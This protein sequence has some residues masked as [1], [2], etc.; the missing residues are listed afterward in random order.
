[1]HRQTKKTSISFCPKLH[2]NKLL[3]HL[4]HDECERVCPHLELVRVETGK[5]LCSP[6][7][8]SEYAYFPLDCFVSLSHIME[9]DSSYAAALVGHEGVLCHSPL[10]DMVMPYT[11]VCQIAGHVV[12]I[13]AD[14]LQ[15]EFGSSHWF[16]RRLLRY[17]QALMAHMGLTAACTRHHAL[18]EQLAHLLLQIGDRLSCDEIALTQESISSLL[19]VRRERINKAALELQ[20]EGIIRYSRGRIH[21]L[22]RPRLLEQSCGCYA[23]IR[24]QFNRLLEEGE[25]PSPCLVSAVK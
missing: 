13:R 1:M 7:E 18:I 22:D 14:I 6:G 3:S 24:S 19:G 2:Q 15:R 8:K 5:V 4:A 16:S 10:E 11:V 12:R 21:I 9:D 20:D 25:V 17:S 23:A